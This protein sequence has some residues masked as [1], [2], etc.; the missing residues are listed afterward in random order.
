MEA[1][2]SIGQQY[3][4]KLQTVASW[5]LA[6]LDDQ[7][8]KMCSIL[9]SQQREQTGSNNKINSKNVTIATQSPAKF[10]ENMNTNPPF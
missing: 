7:C 5:K 10:D 8:S 3:G 1:T 6:P 4:T 9:S 2:G